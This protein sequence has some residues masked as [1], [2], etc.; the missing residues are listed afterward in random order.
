MRKFKNKQEHKM[1]LTRNKSIFSLRKAALIAMD[2]VLVNLSIWLGMFLRFEGAINDEQVSR[3][4]NQE[5][6]VTLLFLLS[7]VSANIY[8]VLWQYASLPEMIRVVFAIMVAGLAILL[9]NE[10]FTWRLSRAVVILTCIWALASVG[11]VR[12]AWRAWC[13]NRI[14]DRRKGEPLMPVMIVGAGYAGSYALAFLRRNRLAYGR[15]VVFVDDDDG[16]QNLRIQNVP[17]LGKISDIPRLVTELAIREIIIAIPSLSGERL[18]NLVALCNSTKCKVRILSNPQDYAASSGK[19][20]FRELN[21]SDFLAREEVKLD[22]DSISAYLGGKTILVTGGGGSIGS[23]ICRQIMRFSPRLL[24]VFDIYEN[25]AYELYNELKQK[26]GADVPVQV[27]VGSIRD[28]KR[29]NEVFRQY[30]PQVVFHAAAHKH[31]PLMEDNPGEAIKNNVLGTLNLLD[32]ASSHGVERLV[33]LSTDKAVNPTSVMGATKRITEMLIQSFARKTAMKCMAVRF[34]NV[35]GSHGSVLPLFEAQ[36]KKGGPLTITHPDIIRYFMTIPEAA[37]LVLQA[38]GIAQSG[39]IY[40]L[41]MG[42][43]VKIMDLAEKLIR[44]YGFE[45]GVDIEMKV[46]GLRAGEKLYEELLMDPEKENMQKTAHDKIFVAPPMDVDD[47]TLYDNIDSLVRAAELDESLVKELL[48]E[49][50]PTYRL[51]VVGEAKVV[52][53]GA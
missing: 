45:P 42:E 6:W 26:Y 4:V 5:A 21:L 36:I 23:E 14:D 29:L 48:V 20:E 22:M 44:F 11:G 12:F 49:A 37:Q 33:Q 52:T 16:K 47:E 51:M 3:M 19:L 7:F 46:V 25:C 1:V 17:V 39:A 35:L 13:A 8:S 34:G 10:L 40:V 28:R 30:H 24:L 32:S 27:L 53:A 41:D 15:P 43:P 2:A 38:G 31:V 9:A 50:V 18:Q